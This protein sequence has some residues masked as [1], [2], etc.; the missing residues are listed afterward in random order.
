MEETQTINR[1][2]KDLYRNVAEMVRETAE[3]QDFIRD[4]EQH[5]A[6][7]QII[8]YL[9][10]LRASAQ[11]SQKDIADKLRCTQSR[12]SKLENSTDGD[13][14]LGDFAGYATA[15]GYKTEILLIP[16]KW[17]TVDE[18]KY[19]A[20]CIKN[21]LDHLAGLAEKDQSIAAGVVGFFAEAKMNLG[22]IIQD[23]AR[24]VVATL[25][26]FGQKAP[27]CPKGSAP[28][29]IR[30]KKADSE[31]QPESD[32]TS[33]CESSDCETAVLS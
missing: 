22:R 30:E 14:R 9:M 23:A 25:K 13:L 4:F 26:A 32:A 24:A 5:L 16:E 17:T 28:I 31:Q 10:V 29:W 19:H 20:C 18:V 6:Q 21:C 2:K 3:D 12:V 15:L 33:S 8:K 7:R 11:M 1:K 27:L